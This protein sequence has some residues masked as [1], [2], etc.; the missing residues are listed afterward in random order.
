MPDQSA[1][2]NLSGDVVALGN[3][4]PTDVAQSLKDG[5]DDKVGYSPLCES[6]LTPSKAM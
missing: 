3:A 5:G 4:A 6:S 1:A 2:E